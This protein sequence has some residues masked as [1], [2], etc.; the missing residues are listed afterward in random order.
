[1]KNKILDGK[2]LNF[3]IWIIVGI[4]VLVLIGMLISLFIAKSI[5]INTFT[6]GLL[7]LSF[8]IILILVNIC[9]VIITGWYAHSTKL[10]LDNQTKTRKIDALE[11]KLEKI[12][13][14]INAE[15]IKFNSYFEP[16]HEQEIPDFYNKVLDS[17]N[18]ELLNINRGYGH[19]SDPN[20]RKY[21][22][23][24]RELSDEFKQQCIRK[25]ERI[26]TFSLYM[27]LNNLIKNFHTELKGN[28]KKEIE[29]LTNLQS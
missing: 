17:L 10:M 5:S 1:M 18:D 27:N 6:L 29:L 26:S 2:D 8:L 16:S 23:E 22:K 9:Y 20:I 7:N 13:S 4:L 19:L 14:P 28:I 25:D 21:Y 15:L 12:Y 11:K 24:F 3:G